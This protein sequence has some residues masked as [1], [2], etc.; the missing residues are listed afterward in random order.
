M[1]GARRG[2]N[3]EK[4][5]KTQRKTQRVGGLEILGGSRRSRCRR[6]GFTPIRNA[7]AVAAA[8]KAPVQ[9]KTTKLPREETRELAM[10]WSSGAACLEPGVGVRHGAKRLSSPT[11][12]G[13]SAGER[14]SEKRVKTAFFDD[15]SKKPAA[16]PVETTSDGRG[17]RRPTR[18]RNRRR[19]GPVGRRVRF[20]KRTG[21]SRKLDDSGATFG[22]VGGPF[23]VEAERLNSADGRGDA[24]AT[25]SENFVPI[26]RAVPT[27][28]TFARGHPSGEATKRPID[29]GGPSSNASPAGH[30]RAKLAAVRRATRRRNRT[31]KNREN[32]RRRS[33]VIDDSASV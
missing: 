4:Y 9:K 20:E 8:A 6:I 13:R 33:K 1:G 21:K 7:P 19:S 16:T 17:R 5:T 23:A 26:G 27:P 15:G 18:R 11:R 32:L 22:T 2:G 31:K 24:S 25:G 3:D 30:G 12:R 10:T 29:A 28:G 14:K